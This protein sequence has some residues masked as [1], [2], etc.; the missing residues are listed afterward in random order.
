VS[1]KTLV[2]LV[3]V[4]SAL[5]GETTESKHSASTSGDDR[6]EVARTRGLADVCALIL[7]ADVDAAF[8]PRVFGNGE[9]GRGNVAGTAKLASVS[10][11]IFTSRGATVR[12]MMT[13][14]VL[15][16]R[17]PND[18]AAVTV[19][20]AKGGAVK[21]NAAPVD[22]PGL[23]DAAYWVNLGS[24]T[25]PMIE[26]NVFKGSRLWLVYSAMVPNGGADA[27]LAGLTSLARA[28]LGRL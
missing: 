25:R 16:R 11:C 24:S 22:V 17:A 5:S 27:A 14:S 23:G 26:L 9:Q 1:N 4:C 10:S 19:A 21:L 18:K 6:S 15:A 8:A 7:K 3:A 2:L 28:T 12:E 20:I 13:V